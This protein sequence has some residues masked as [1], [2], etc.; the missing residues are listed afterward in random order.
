MQIYAADTVPGGQECFLIG[1]N[2]GYMALPNLWGGLVY[3]SPVDSLEARA[4]T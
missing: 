2:Q 1:L 4:M 3:D